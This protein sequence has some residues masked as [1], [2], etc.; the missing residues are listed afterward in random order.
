MLLCTCHSSYISASNDTQWRRYCSHVELYVHRE[1]PGKMYIFLG[2]NIFIRW[3]DKYLHIF[4]YFYYLGLLSK[5]SGLPCHPLL[6]PDYDFENSTVVPLPEFLDSKSNISVREGD[7][8]T[9]P[10]VVRNLGTKQVSCQNLRHK[11][12][13][14]LSCL[15]H[16]LRKWIL[17]LKI[18]HHCFLLFFLSHFVINYMQVPTAHPG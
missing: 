5:I 3:N 6:S 10:C 1:R 12:N 8:A 11:F 7:M 17:A 2:L 4:V 14:F 18:P 13:T 9:L 15:E 16:F